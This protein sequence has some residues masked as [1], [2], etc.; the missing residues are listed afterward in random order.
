MPYRYRV[1]A[2]CTAYVGETWTVTSPR[3]LTDDEV[4]AYLLYDEDPDEA[5]VTLS[6][7]DQDISDE[8]DRSVSEVEL[9]ESPPEPA[10]D[11]AYKIYR[12]GFP[13]DD[14]RD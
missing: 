4:E 2:T 3:P 8:H 12:Q 9:V 1:R 7:T 14:P 13:L 5:G 6:C 10:P 11:P